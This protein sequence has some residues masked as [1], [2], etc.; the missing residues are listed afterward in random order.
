[1]GFK[2]FRMR[3]RKRY[4]RS[5]KQVEAFSAQTEQT[6]ERQFLGRFNKLRQVRRFVIGWLL[7]LVLL[8]GGVL[9]QTVLLSGYFQSY[10][11]VP[12]GIYTE[13]V[14]GRFTTA[15][16]LF[17]TTDFEVTVSHLIF[18][19]LLTYNAQARLVNDLSSGYSVDAKG[20]TYTVHL[21]PNL[22]W[23]DGKPLTAKD[24]AFTYQTIQNPDIKSPLLGSWQG[25]TIAAPNPTT[26]TFKL[27]GV[28]ASFPYNLTTGIV[29]QH[30]LT[31]IP[32]ADLRS[33][34]FNT[35]RPVGSGAFA[36]QT[37]QV[38]GSDANDQQEQIALLPFKGYQGGK[39]KLQEFIVRS[40]SNPNRLA[41]DLKSGQ[42]TAAEGLSTVP[43]HLANTKAVIQ[44]SFLLSAAN[45]VFFKTSSGQLADK[46]VRQALVSSTNVPAIVAS[47]S[48][49]TRAVR[50]PLLQ[51]QLAYDPS[52][53]QSGFDLKHANALLDQDGWV[54]G[55]N[56]IRAKDGKPLKFTLTA[57]DS[58]EYRAVCKLVQRQWRTSGVDL[59]LQ[60]QDSINFQSTLSSHQYDA[61]LYG[62]SIGADPDVFVYW[63]SS[64]ADVRSANRL[65]LSEYKNPIADN[66][67]EA[68]R[69]RLS[70]ELRVIKY[71]PFLQ[72]WQQDAPAVGLY[73]PRIL[74]LTNGAVAGLTDHPINSAT[75]RF[76]NVQNW[77]IR[78]AKVTNQ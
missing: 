75:D 57:S 1:M 73:Q 68:G 76:D 30:L 74:Y 60:F 24:V 63:D 16:P 66:A 64:Q 38:S 31:S 34:D 8:I 11:P 9:V 53:T 45:M 35:M 59:Q 56:G 49:M 71:K 61:V 2:L 37:I 54:M 19:G 26:V 15:N 58:P 17:A 33:A 40:Y 28:L 5:Q 7:L 39:P 10:R 62:I 21:K 47:L 46:T 44:H 51:G 42:I 50:E 13:G 18:N 12:G 22:T 69:T 3:F 70:P 67:L 43:A 77:E 41:N 27:P 20:T 29:P 55:Q 25:I 14:L 32:P 78:Q 6:I 23:Q 36:W 48:Y 72:A 65:N 4:R 52:T